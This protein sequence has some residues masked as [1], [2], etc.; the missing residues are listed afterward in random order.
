MGGG[1]Q[2]DVAPA[3]DL[4]HAARHEQVRSLADAFRRV[5]LAGGP[6]A[7]AAC[8][9]RAAEIIGRELGWSASQRFDATREF[10]QGSWRS[11]FNARA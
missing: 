9:M 3:G 6:C 10:V 4:T 7:G 1:S 11:D 5:G 2:L 8:I